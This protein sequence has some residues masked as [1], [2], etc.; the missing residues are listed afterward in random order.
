MKLVEVIHTTH[1]NADVVKQISEFG[2]KIGKN[3][4]HCGDTPG[5]IVNRL[6]VPFLCQVGSTRYLAVLYFFLF[7]SPVKFNS[8]CFY[9]F[10]FFFFLAFSPSPCRCCVIQSALVQ[11]DTIHRQCFCSSAE[12]PPSPTSTSPCSSAPAT[13]WARCTCWTTS[14]ST[15]R[16]ASSSAGERSTPKSP[17]SSSP[18]ASPRRSPTA[19]WVE[20]LA[21]ASTTGTATR[22]WT[23]STRNKL[24]SLPSALPCYAVIRWQPDA[25]RFVGVLAKLFL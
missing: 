5:F 8:T 22:S 20:R 25:I 6:L 2:T 1:T 15:P 19:T 17:H 4:V 7:C 13:P 21:R 9:H 11:Y 16:T 12:T 14:A 10:S 24:I 23:P 3:T 18:S